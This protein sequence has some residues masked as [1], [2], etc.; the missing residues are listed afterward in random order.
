MGYRSDVALRINENIMEVV[1]IYRKLD[2][3]VDDM[4]NDTG[5]SNHCSYSWDHVKWYNGDAGVDAIDA[6]MAK[7]SEDDYGFIRIGEETDDIEYRG[8]PCEYDMYV[9]RS[10]E[11]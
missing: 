8:M 5:W 9:N 7:I 1:D 10:I 3:E 4:F 2:K 6:L 11:W